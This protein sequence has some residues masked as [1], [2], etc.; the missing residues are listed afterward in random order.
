MIQLIYTSAATAPFSVPALQVLLAGARTN[1]TALTVSGLLLHADGA[2]LQ[3]LEGEAKH[4]EPLYD[5]IAGDRRH[6]RILRLLVREIEERNFPDWSMGFADVTGRASA[7]P[8]YRKTTGFADL[9]GDTA[10]ILR[11]VASFRDGRWRAQA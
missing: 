3:V 8:G 4:V 5:K 1:N 11:I 2:F 10:A 6:R 7:L 9:L